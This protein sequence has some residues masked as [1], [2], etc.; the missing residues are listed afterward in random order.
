MYIWSR[1]YTP[2]LYTLF[3]SWY[4]ASAADGEDGAAEEAEASALQKHV[5]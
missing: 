2:P 4:Q 1:G 3:R 5:R